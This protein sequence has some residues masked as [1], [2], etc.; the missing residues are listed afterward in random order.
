M[1]VNTKKHNSHIS[2]KS[3][4]N[5]LFKNN[6]ILT[7]AGIYVLEANNFVNKQNEIYEVAKNK[8]RL[9]GVAN[10]IRRI[11]PNN[12]SYIFRKNYYVKTVRVYNNI[13][14]DIGDIRENG[15]CEKHFIYLLENFFGF[16][17]ST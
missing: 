1:I 7:L 10:A 11:V 14:K 2:R 12:K 16:K 17:Y 9:V 5:L 3:I 13:P 15:I 6:S 4:V 8:S